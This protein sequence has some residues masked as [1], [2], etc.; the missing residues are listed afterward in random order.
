MQNLKVTEEY[1]DKLKGFLDQ[2]Q[3]KMDAAFDAPRGK[4][5]G[6]PKKLTD[7]HGATA[8]P[9][10]SGIM[11]ILDGERNAVQLHLRAHITACK[12][13]LE[14]A[15]AMYQTTDA[16]AGSVLNQQMNTRS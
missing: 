9:G 8:T 13:A 15:K 10:S 16:D 3:K 12:A 2:A 4:L 11:A 5:G 7:T 14:R 6:Y 1:L